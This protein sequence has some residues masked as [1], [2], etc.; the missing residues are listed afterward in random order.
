MTWTKALF[1]SV[2][3]TLSTIALFTTVFRSDPFAIFEF[4]Y[5]FMVVPGLPVAGT[6]L[7][8][9]YA[10]VSDT[11]RWKPTIVTTAVFLVVGFLHFFVVASAAASV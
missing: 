2:A 3:Y 1:V 11:P 4:G 6:I 5:I 7:L 9:Y 10:R 8:W